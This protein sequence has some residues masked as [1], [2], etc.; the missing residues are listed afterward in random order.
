MLSLSTDRQ[1]STVQALAVEKTYD[2]KEFFSP[3]S[4]IIC[5]GGGVYTQNYTEENSKIWSLAKDSLVAVF[6]GL[7]EG[8]QLE[9]VEISRWNELVKGRAVR[10]VLPFDMALSDIQMMLNLDVFPFGEETKINSI[11]ISTHVPDAIYFGNESEHVYFRLY[12]N[13][14]L[15]EISA[16]IEVVEENTS[17]EYRRVEDLFGLS[18]SSEDPFDKQNNS[19][20]PITTMRVDF[21]N[22][23]PEVDVTATDDSAL[24]SYAN[25]AFGKQF[26]FVKKM[27]DV[28]GSII[29]LYGY[30]NKALRLGA[31]GSIDFTQ[32]LESGTSVE[33]LDL[34]AAMN[35]ALNYVDQYG[36]IPG[37]LY[38][39]N[40][41]VHEDED[42]N[43]V[44][45]FDFA[46]KI[47]ELPVML[48]NSRSGDSIRVDIVGDRVT[49]FFRRI[50][51]YRDSFMLDFYPRAL[52]INEVLER[53]SSIIEND[54]E[55]SL[56]EGMS[57]SS[58]EL[59]TRILCDISDVELAYF[60][61]EDKSY[62]YPVWKLDIGELSYV[63]RLYDGR[64]LSV[65]KK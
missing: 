35:L 15:D 37:S 41:T 31:D 48:D 17:I 39:S 5:F 54:Y 63:F 11:L 28:D 42:K 50:H 62:L 64:L 21:V 13:A 34:R 53:N 9:P 30:G 32:R 7:Q 6:E 51:K 25:K 36:G 45:G 23:T 3:Q 22:I 44:Y 49:N 8:D 19:V 55:K 24:K 58:S 16:E 46:Y 65:S 47:K 60:L 57:L 26:N 52:T 2:L 56:P 18:T 1:D 10:F 20:F 14:K 38:L 4:F 59:W 40:Y 12:G 29:Y 43:K 33:S 27:Q 61:E